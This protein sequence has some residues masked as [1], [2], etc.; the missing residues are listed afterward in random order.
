M[1]FP[2][3]IKHKIQQPYKDMNVENVSSGVI[4][5]ILA[6]T[7]PAALILQAA[8]VGHFSQG[9]T[10]SWLF[11]VY[12]FGGLL[13]IV[14][15]IIFRVPI[16]AAHSMSGVAFL[17]TVI[18]DYSYPE[19]IGCYIVSGLLIFLVGVTNLFSK[20]MA[21]IPKEVIASMLSGMIAVYLIH[22]VKA[23]HALPITGSLAILGYFLFIKWGKYIPPVIG[24]IGFGIIG[25]LVT[26]AF[27]VS[28][29][30]EAYFMPAVHTP[31]FSIQSL[32]VIS[33]PLTLLILSNDIAAGISALQNF[34]F[35]P[36]IRKALMASGVASMIAGFFGGQS[37]NVAGMMTTITADQGAGVKK[38]RYVASVVS[39]I[40]ILLFGIF[41]WK[42]VPFVHAFPKAFIS[43]IAGF[44]LLS[45]FSSSISIA[46]SSRKHRLSSVVSFTIA[47]SNLSFFHINAPVWSLIFG[48]AIAKIFERKHEKDSKSV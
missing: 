18:S 34:K 9:Q 2:R 5:S 8:G 15:P 27:H 21:I 35:N 1:R 45:P 19:L 31:E 12:F 3:F 43:I 29:V 25:L 10:I 7:A 42:I 39:G 24:A 14:L 22:L 41:S 16:T 20:I 28:K 23:I 44:A 37:A 33:I 36:P 17:A 48:L 46:F 30:N 13:S 47:F 26:N 40:I 6:M 4:S 11:A 32:L 38:S